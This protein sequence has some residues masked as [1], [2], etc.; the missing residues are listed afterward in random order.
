MAAQSAKIEAGEVYL[1]RHAKWLDDLQPRS[2]PSLMACTMIKWIRF[3]RPYTGCLGRG[4]DLMP[5]R[6]RRGVWGREARARCHLTLNPS[7]IR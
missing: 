6:P 1:P 5:L 2:S 3:L 4:G 7:L